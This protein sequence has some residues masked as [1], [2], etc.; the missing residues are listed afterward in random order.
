MKKFL[1]WAF[2]IVFVIPIILAVIFVP[3]TDV[4]KATAGV[5]TGMAAKLAC[6]GQH[7]SLLSPQVA[8]S[9]V[10]SY[11]PDFVPLDTLLDF[12]TLNNGR[13][14]RVSMLDSSPISATYRPGL[15]CSLDIGNHQLL[16]R[17][18]IPLTKANPGPWPGGEQVNTID[19]TQQDTLERIMA[20]DNAA[21]YKSRALLVA[22]K[23]VIVA[24]SYA[25]GFDENSKLLG[26]SMGKSLTAI[27]VG[28]LE[29]QGE[30]NIADKD[31]FA[32]WD[33]DP[34]QEI[35]IENLLHMSSG[36]DFDEMYAPG[37][38]A[39]RM[40]FTEHSAANVAIAS[41]AKYTPG[42]HWAYSSGTTNL[43]TK[44]LTS[45]LGGPQQMFNFLANEVYRPLGMANTVFEPD[46]SGVPVGSSYIYASA[47]DWARLGQL[48][49]NGGTLNNRRLISEAWVAQSITPN[50][51]QNE[52][53]YGYQFWLNSATT[54]EYGSE[55]DDK[56]W[57]KL[58]TD[59]YAMSGNRQQSVV[60]IPSQDLV[61]V[62]LGWTAGRYPMQ[63]NFA[64]IIAGLN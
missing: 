29:H 31:L 46:P 58:P 36:L 53:R 32:D 55:T 43:L 2:V 40:L 48:M 12:Q 9:E 17:I 52:P 25:D 50:H 54:E 59:A 22:H 35:T 14:I 27:M 5:A 60:I 4:Y 13:T 18:S 16:D 41:P 23:G 15:G 45:K 33:S 26:W 6:S 51:S 28:M 64:E 61:I 56:R 21:G 3:R 34:R 49:L 37:S 39:T 38:D 63:D 1:L 44:I 8:K 10:A 47:R 20:R 30:L 62:R 7:V 11:V 42:E 24:E 57:D 19:P